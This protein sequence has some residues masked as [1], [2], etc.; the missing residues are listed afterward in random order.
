MILKIANLKILYEIYHN[1]YK[2]KKLK[3]KLKFRKNLK[4]NNKLKK[5]L[6]NILR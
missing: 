3:N 5:L 4:N 6:M 1:K 2:I